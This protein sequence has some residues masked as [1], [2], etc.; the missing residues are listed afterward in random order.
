[1]TVVEATKLFGD[2]LI[3]LHCAAG[4]MQSVGT[5]EQPE[6][7]SSILHYG[8]TVS[9]DPYFPPSSPSRSTGGFYSLCL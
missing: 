2:A 8:G 5:G 6:P 9:Q 4:S 3:R 7:G 1:M